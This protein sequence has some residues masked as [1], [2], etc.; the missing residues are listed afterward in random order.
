MQNRPANALGRLLRRA[1]VTNGYSLRELAAKAGV[2]AAFIN[3]IEL[4]ERGATDDV[5][6][7]IAEVLGADADVLVRACA[8]DRLRRME[9]RVAAARRAIR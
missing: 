5:L 6:K 3:R 4:S 9:A 1:R 7:R 2:S 8:V